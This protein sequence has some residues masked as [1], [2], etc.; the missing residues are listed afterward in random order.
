MDASSRI[1]F[2]LCIFM[3]FLSFR[4]YLKG[5]GTPDGGSV[6]RNSMMA[7]YHARVL[8]SVKEKALRR[9]KL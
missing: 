1:I 2:W 3:L 9:L 6:F 7:I 8:R 4:R 5:K